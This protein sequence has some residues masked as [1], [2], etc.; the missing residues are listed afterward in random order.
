MAESCASDIDCIPPT[1]SSAERRIRAT[2][3]KGRLEEAGGG[4]LI[5]PE[6]VE[7][8]S[9][10]EMPWNPTLLTFVALWISSIRG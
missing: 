1:K 4:S 9:A 10:A 7:A 2:S 8:G 3:P 5:S 6:P